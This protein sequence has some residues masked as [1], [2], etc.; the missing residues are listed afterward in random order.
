MDSNTMSNLPSRLANL[1]TVSRNP[2][3]SPGDDCTTAKRR[4]GRPA[5]VDGTR[6]SVLLVPMSPVSFPV[7]EAGGEEATRLRKGLK[8]VFWAG[9]VPLWVLTRAESA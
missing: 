3:A 8:S 1:L 7:S 6:R 2:T 4:S 5:D 9:L